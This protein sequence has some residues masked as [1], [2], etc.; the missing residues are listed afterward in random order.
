VEGSSSGESVARDG[1]NTAAVGTSRSTT[2][3][4]KSNEDVRGQN[5]DR[6]LVSSLAALA[7]RLAPLSG[8]KHVILLS[9]GS[10]RRERFD[11]YDQASEMHARFRAAGVMLS[12]IDI[13]IDKAAPS[14][15]AR[16]IDIGSNPLLGILTLQTGGSVAT[17]FTS[18]RSMH[19]VTYVLGF[20]PQGPQ[21]K[22]NEIKVRVKNV[23][24]GT[25][26]R[27][28]KEYVALSPGKKNDDLMLADVLLNDIPQNGVTLDLMVGV[29]QKLASVDA[30]VPGRELLAHASGK[31]LVLDVFFYVFNTK[32]LPVDWTYSRVT[33]DV[34]KGREF[35]A[36]NPYKISKTFSL[37]PGRYAAKA[38][39]RVVGS[40]ITGFRR[41]DF[42]VAQ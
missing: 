7:D 8:I 30:V 35:L 24:W 28:R 20:R 37:R 1:S 2:E 33:I 10:A 22:Q 9:G 12:A 38:V 26:V 21:K 3:F 4:S 34:E 13:A 17:S 19:R 25:S 18:L 15:R 41:A 39:V 42:N 14:P 31:P 5:D 11:L 16:S 29:D 40:D 36:A 6:A 23:P 27:Y 32:N